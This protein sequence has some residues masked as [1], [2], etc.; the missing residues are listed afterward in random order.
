MAQQHTQAELHAEIEAIQQQIKTAKSELQTK[1]QAKAP[2]SEFEGLLATLKSLKI[3]LTEK[4]KQLKEAFPEAAGQ[5]LSKKEAKKAASKAAKKKTAGKEGNTEVIGS[6]QDKSADNFGV[7]PL[8]RSEE[9]TAKVFTNVSDLNASLHGQTVCVRARFYTV[10]GKGNKLAFVV[11]RQRTATVQAVLEAGEVVSVAMIKFIKSIHRESLVD[12][13][14]VIKAGSEV[15]FCTQKDVDLKV[16]KFFVVSQTL[17]SELP[18]LI[19]DAS[20]PLPVLKAQKAEVKALQAKITQVEAELQAKKGSPEE[21][22]LKTQLEKLVKQKSEAQ[23]YVKVG[24]KTRLDN[25]ILDLRTAASNAIFRI[26][27]GVC[28]LFREFLLSKNFTEIHSPKMISAASE[29]GAEVF[30]LGY[31]NGFA[32]LAQSPQLYKQM[33][34]C[35]DFERVFEIG[36]V[37]RAEKSLTHR[38]LTEFVGLDLE[39]AF[40]EHYHEVL[41]ILDGLFIYMFDGLK[42]RFALEIEAVRTQYPFEDLKYT[43]PSPRITFK[44]AI[45]M[46]REDGIEI[47]DFDDLSTP[48]EKHLGSLVKKKYGVD[49][50]ILDKFPSAVR[51]FYTMP[52][53]KNPNYSNSYDLFIRN[54][55]ICSG[56]QRIHDAAFLEQRANEKGVSI[57]TI[58]A[59]IDAFKY[60]APPHAG[61][62]VGLERVVMLYLGLRNI[63][64]TSLFPRDPTRLVP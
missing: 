59:Y 15:A 58:Q 43:W 50:Y 8:I 21:A 64:K 63:R 44:E 14:G 34:I 2:Q 19:E 49:F 3:K 55:E 35:A 29:G 28:Q 10:R 42:S 25:R 24:Q 56:A 4:E 9:R 53:P 41:D 51:P 16:T 33:A 37:F 26:Q 61:G 52:D 60:G 45:A 48:Q 31:F 46:L 12:V 22:K 11:L 40:Y 18:L 27:S 57:P 47:G 17:A 39:M 54:E 20:R 23:K 13:E 1:K 7:R 36:P 38:H 30:K 62:G 6:E 32:Y 5:G